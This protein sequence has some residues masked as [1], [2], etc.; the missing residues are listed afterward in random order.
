[1]KT[2]L[3][4]LKLGFKYC[5]STIQCSRQ[6]CKRV[7]LSPHPLQHLLF[8]DLLMIAI[9]TSVRCYL[10]MV[11]ICIP[12]IINDFEHLFICLLLICMSSLEKCL[13]RSF[14][15]FVNWV[16]YFF[17]VEFYKMYHWQICS[18][19]LWGVFLFCWWFSL[20]CQNFDVA[21]LFIF[22]FV[23]LA[24]RDIS[25]R[26]LLWA[27]SKILLPMFSSMIFMLLDLTFK[28][29]IHFEFFLCVV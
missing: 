4:K 23:S 13:F 27:I 12:L 25:D 19:I 3:P 15:H 24:W 2:I 6:Q 17:G 14:A 10:I 29:L 28:S 1:M 5:F 7:P 9:L 11:L 8:V 20:L 21:H 26:I 16:V 22:S 18:P